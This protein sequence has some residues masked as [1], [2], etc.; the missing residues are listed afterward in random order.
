MGAQWEKDGVGAQGGGSWQ[1]KLATREILLLSARRPM[2]FLPLLIHKLRNM[3]FDPFH[4]VNLTLE[5]GVLF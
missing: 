4:S 5:S 3:G 1:T 2:H